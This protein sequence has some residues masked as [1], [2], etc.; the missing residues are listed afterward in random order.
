MV[1]RRCDCSRVLNYA[2]RGE[3]LTLRPF[4]GANEQPRRRTILLVE[5]EPFVLDATTRILES[6]GFEV[7]SAEDAPAARKVFADRQA[8]I[9]LVM[10]DMVLPGQSGQQLAEDLRYK[11]AELAILVT[12]GYG[13]P[14]SETESA[15][16]HT[17]FLPKPYSK[18]LLINKIEK[19]LA[20]H[21]QANSS[22]Q[23][24]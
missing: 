16:L 22:T 18:S 5:D 23:T 7:L 8:D 14:D 6:A 1:V 11:S 20:S 3:R 12:S 13:N 17:Y 9:A 15:E 21:P 24:R 10:T 19:I 2:N 4:L